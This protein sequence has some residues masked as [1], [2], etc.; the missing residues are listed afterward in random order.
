MPADELPRTRPAGFSLIEFTVVLVVISIISA[1]LLDR[2]K[3]Y[4]E[5]AERATM[6]ATAAA[7]QAALHLRIAGHLATGAGAAQIEALADQNPVE[8][9]AREPDN[10]AGAYDEQG[11]AD[12]P[13]GSWYFDLSDRTLVYRVRYGR[14]FVPDAAGRKEVHY[15]ARVEYGRLEPTSKLMGIKIAEFRPVHPYRWAV[16]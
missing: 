5:Q 8:W 13:E 10:Y 14:A 15:R 4:Q 1:V 12:V 11:A 6:E 16:D 3:F 2:L 7:I 9:L